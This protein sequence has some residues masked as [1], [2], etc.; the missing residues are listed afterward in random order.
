MTT[1]EPICCGSPSRRWCTRTLRNA[2]RVYG[3]QCTTCGAWFAMRHTA[4]VPTPTAVYDPAIREHYLAEQHRQRAAARSAARASRVARKRAWLQDHAAYLR[5]PRWLALR[6]LVLNRDHHKCQ[7]CLAAPASHVH[8][9]T[10]I[11]YQH[12]MAFDLIS[13][14]PA[15]HRAI[16]EALQSARKA[17]RTKPRAAKT[18]SLDDLSTWQSNS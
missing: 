7:G 6:E 8:H 15:C 12:E 13:L 18:L 1:T 9:L 10:Y 16:H 5:S 14:C 2:H 3:L 11:R 17:K 4:D